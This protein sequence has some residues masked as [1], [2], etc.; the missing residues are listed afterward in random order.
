MAALIF[1]L[2]RLF[3]LL[4]TLSPRRGL[5]ETPPPPPPHQN[6]EPPKTAPPM[7]NH[8]AGDQQL[9]LPPA[10]PPHKADHL[11]QH[12]SIAGG[13]DID[14]KRLVESISDHLYGRGNLWA[15][16]DD[17]SLA[18]PQC[19]G[20]RRTR[21]AMRIHMGPCQNSLHFRSLSLRDRPH[22]VQRGNG[23]EQGQGPDLRDLRRLFDGGIFGG[24]G[25]FGSSLNF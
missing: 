14:R 24:F 17:V 23:G 13:M 15:R 1:G 3:K 20:C 6:I 11:A 12:S 4:G 25:Y 8:E 22:C 7:T 9:L 10:V 19:A 2:T 21:C 5:G 18:Q 16:D